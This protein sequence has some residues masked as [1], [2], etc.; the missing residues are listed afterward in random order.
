MRRDVANALLAA[1]TCVFIVTCA[2]TSFASSQVASL[3]PWDNLLNTV[4]SW[5][6]EVVAPGA[7][8]L[9]IAAGAAAFALS[10]ASHATRRL[11]KLGLGAALALMMVRLLNS[12][13]PY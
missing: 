6:T 4:A 5:L 7:L 1:S 10:G 11:A 2:T 3:M 13:L 9:G 12:I 8:K